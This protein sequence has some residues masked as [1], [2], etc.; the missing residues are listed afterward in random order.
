MY[1]MI[2]GCTLKSSKNKIDCTLC[3]EGW[4][5]KKIATRYEEKRVCPNHYK[6]FSEK[7][8][9]HSECPGVPM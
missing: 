2:E 4:K 1:C 6:E 7:H 5:L 8:K 9:A 3:L